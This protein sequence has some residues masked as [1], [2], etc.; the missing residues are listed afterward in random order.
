MVSE[1]W[2]KANITKFFQTWES[3]E[4]TQ[5]NI[6]IG[7]DASD[8][9]SIVAEYTLRQ[10]HRETASD[11]FLKHNQVLLISDWINYYPELSM[12]S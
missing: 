11:H 5:T 9:H 8:P 10:V 12:F 6:L 4:T 2:F 7:N 3:K 1:T